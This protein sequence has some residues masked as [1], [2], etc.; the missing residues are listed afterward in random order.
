MRANPTKPNLDAFLE[1]ATADAKPVE[2]KSKPVDPVPEPATPK[3]SATLEQ[4]SFRLPGDL[5]RKMKRVVLDEGERL[6]RRYTETE[7]IETAIREYI[8][9]LGY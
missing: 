7:L 9:K 4:K 3:S 1:G 8:I 6:N 5:T 2:A